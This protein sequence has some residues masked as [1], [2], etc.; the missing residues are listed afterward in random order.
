MSPALQVDSLPA[1]PSGKSKTLDTTINATLESMV[2]KQEDRLQI[3]TKKHSTLNN[4][5]AGPSEAKRQSDPNIVFLAE[6]LE[7]KS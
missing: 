5:G 7:A 1:E 4:I 6:P 2:R 3:S